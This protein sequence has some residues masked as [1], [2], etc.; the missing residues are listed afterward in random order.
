MGEELDKFYKEMAV[1]INRGSMSG[2]SAVE[3]TTL[4]LYDVWLK[5]NKLYVSQHVIKPKRPYKRKSAIKV[6]DRVTIVRL[7]EPMKQFAAVGDCVQVKA[8][9][10]SPAGTRVYFCI[11]STGFRIWLD[12]GEIEKV[13]EE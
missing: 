5:R 10:I 6:G 13:E 4:E 1:R 2:F 3:R 7:T 8:I 12:H 11:G 9:N